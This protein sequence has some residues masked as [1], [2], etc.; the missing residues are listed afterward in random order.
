MKNATIMRITLVLTLGAFLT[1]PAAAQEPARA[2]KQLKYPQ[3]RDIKIPDVQRLT[4]PN[5]MQ[6][7]LLEDHELPL[8]HVSAM[9]RA[10]SIYEPADKIGLAALR[11]HKEM[12]SGFMTYWD[13]SCSSRLGR[14]R[15]AEGGLSSS[16]HWTP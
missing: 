3:L 8:I 12:N 11:T 5:G 13:R 6:L 4:L 10:G 7:F 15:V 16:G 14:P 1:G 9:I 2:Y